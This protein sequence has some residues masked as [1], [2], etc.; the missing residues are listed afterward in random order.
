MFLAWGV[1]WSFKW[2]AFEFPFVERL[3][4]VSP[5]LSRVCKGRV[6]FTNTQITQIYENSVFHFL[7]AKKTMKF[8][9]QLLFS[10]ILGLAIY[11]KFS[12]SYFVHYRLFITHKTIQFFYAIFGKYERVNTNLSCWCS[13]SVKHSMMMTMHVWN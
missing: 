3:C 9:Y 5:V 1:L 12:G 2:I 7:S 13:I 10:V 4:C 8:F 11:G 6:H